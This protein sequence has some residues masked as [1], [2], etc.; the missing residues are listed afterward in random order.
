MTPANA[1]NGTDY[2]KI[3][4]DGAWIWMPP[5]YDA[6]IHPEWI[7]SRTHAEDHWVWAPAQ[8]RFWLHWTPYRE[9]AEPWLPPLPDPAD[10]AEFALPP[11]PHQAI[12]VQWLLTHRFALLADDMGLGKTKQSIDAVRIRRNRGDGGPVLVVTT[13]SGV[14]VWIREI[15]KND[16]GAT[17][18][19]YRRQKD[20]YSPP[21]QWIITTYGTL[22]GDVAHPSF[23]FVTG[24]ALVQKRGKLPPRIIDPGGALPF[25]WHTVILDE[26]HQCKNPEAQRTLAV[27]R[28]RPTYGIM[29]SGT[30]IINTSEDAWFPLYWSRLLP[31]TPEQF[32]TGFGTMTPVGWRASREGEAH[33][34]R[35]LGWIMIRR[36]KTEVLDLPEKIRTPLWVPLHGQQAEAYR[37]VRDEW[38]VWVQDHPQ[39][40]QNVLEQLLRLKQ[41]CA[42]PHVVDPA[43]AV[44]THA[45]WEVF[46]DQFL[47]LLEA[48]QKIVIFTQFRGQWQWLAN[49]LQA[50]GVTGIHGQITGKARTMAEQQFQTDP[51]IRVFL[52]TAAGQEAITL[53]A[54]QTLVCFDLPWS[55]AYLNQMEDRIHRIGQTGTVNIYYLL[56][57][58]T[59]EEKIMRTNLREKQAI[60][61]LLLHPK[62]FV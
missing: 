36:M 48:G 6:Y 49:K 41:V 7:P 38:L 45:K 20:T 53:T 40:V 18:S 37:Q 62:Q 11:F 50:Y 57:E 21:S 1:I 26:V 3:Q 15:E 12:G 55:P 27:L 51:A 39:A 31:W 33:I 61:D 23:R 56:A 42:G 17:V 52:T 9:W 35:A 24:K 47:P 10:P 4:E 34:Q 58:H 28:L 25:P 43:A 54:A 16:P 19:V 2:L 30:P 60:M 5:P 8:S 14:G 32:K 44:T 22:R 46:A 59:V 29:L 13:R